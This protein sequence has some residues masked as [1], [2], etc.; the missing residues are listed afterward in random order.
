MTLAAPCRDASR[1]HRVTAAVDSR[2]VIESAV[3]TGAAA[4]LTMRDR[5]T[6]TASSCR[7]RGEPARARRAV[8]AYLLRSL[9]RAGRRR[10]LCRVQLLAVDAWAAYRFDGYRR[11]M[12]RAADDPREPA[13]TIRLG[14]QLRDRSTR[15]IASPDLPDRGHGA[16]R[17]FR[18]DRGDGRHAN[19]T[20]RSPIRRASPISI[21]PIALRSNSRQRQTP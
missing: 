20:G 12:A 7:R 5:A 11:G 19:P 18:G 4:A 14:E 9:P 1:T 13:S 17:P 15:A 10:G 2:D 8:A 16:T 6:S 21:M 3:A